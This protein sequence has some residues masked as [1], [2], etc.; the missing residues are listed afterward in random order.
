MKDDIVALLKEIRPDVN[1]A[2]ERGLISNE[3]LDSFDIIMLLS[4]LSQ[5]YSVEID[6][7]DI[8]EEN[9]DSIDSIY[10]LIDGMLKKH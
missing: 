8:S 9:F 5:E 1:F 7:D 10:T 4:R 2:E 3:I 6:P